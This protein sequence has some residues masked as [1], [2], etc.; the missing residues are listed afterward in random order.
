[1]ISIIIPVYNSR[2]WLKRCI[3]SVL[4]QTCK[5]WELLLIDDGSSDGSEII[6]DSY[7]KLD[8]R[9]RVIHKKNGGVSSARNEGIRNATFQWI[10]F[11]D[12]DDYI[13]QDAIHC[14]IETIN[15]HKACLYNFRYYFNYDAK[16]CEFINGYINGMLAIDS[17]NSNLMYDV[18][19]TLWHVWDN[20]YSKDIIEKY[21]LK[22]NENQKLGEDQMFNLYYIQHCQ[23]LYFSDKGFYQYFW[24]H[25]PQS[26]TFG[27]QL[28]TERASYAIEKY[29]MYKLLNVN[30]IEVEKLYK[31]DV[32]YSIRIAIQ[33]KTI[34]NV[35]HILV[36]KNMIRNKLW[37]TKNMFLFTIFSL[38][39]KVRL[40]IPKRPINKS[41]EKSL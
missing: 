35:A 18:C 6:C 22:F 16:K 32:M 4:A 28:S 27:K 24:A 14:Y 39:Y 2:K 1:M 12:S 3:D 19:R 38:M 40:L 34:R 26:L 41:E 10:T 8:T 36:R 20:I 7:S 11:M 21:S 13:E 9:I 5:K 17:A 15:T 29:S 23:Y 37:F 30:V 31:S 33:T 25:N